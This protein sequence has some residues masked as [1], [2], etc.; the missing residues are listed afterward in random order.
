[1]S[2]GHYQRQEGTGQHSVLHGLVCVCGWSVVSRCRQ[3]LSPAFPCSWCCL[4]ELYVLGWIPFPCRGSN[5]SFVLHGGVAMRR[6]RWLFLDG[7]LELFLPLC[8]ASCLLLCL[9]IHLG[10]RWINSEIGLEWLL[11]VAPPTT[12]GFPGGLNRPQQ[13]RCERMVDLETHSYSMRYFHF[14]EMSRC[15]QFLVAGERLCQGKILW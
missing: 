6:K 10:I 1:M 15:Q 13:L 9:S 5:N 3:P 8:I 7:A 4:C 14:Q 11:Q 12:W 2:I